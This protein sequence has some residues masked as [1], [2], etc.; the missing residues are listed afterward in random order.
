MFHNRRLR[1]VCLHVDPSL[2]LR[3]L[4]DAFALMRRFWQ[5]EAALTVVAGDFNLISRDDSRFQAGGGVGGQGDWTRREVAED[6]VS[7]LLELHQPGMTHRRFRDGRLCCASRID[8]VYV[9]LSPA[10]F[11]LFVGIASVRGN[12]FDREFPF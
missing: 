2:S 9:S 12:L 5:D 4:R 11:S 10:A 6:A 1:L 8:R 3:R 7:G